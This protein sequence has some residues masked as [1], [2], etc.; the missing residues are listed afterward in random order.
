MAR[1]AD[2]VAANPG[3]AAKGRALLYRTGSGEAILA[4]VRGDGPPR[5]HP[6]AIEQIDDGLYAFILPSGKLTDLEEDGRYAL[7]AYPDADVPHE[8][9]V[10]GRAR[11]VDD[12][13][14]ARIAGGW[15]FDVGSAPAFEFL[16]DEALL[17]ERDSR[18]DWPPR[19]TAWRPA[20]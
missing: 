8:F 17:G 3:L 15:P 7:H 14:R 5:L 1:W 16:I 2:L 12:E 6:I 19:Y 4:T 20:R 9:A 10:R 18:D 13:T 11:P